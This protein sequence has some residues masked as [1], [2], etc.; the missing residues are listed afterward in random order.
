MTNGINVK[1]AREKVFKHI[2]LPYR[3]L[4]WYQ[5][6]GRLKVF[7][8]GDG[9]RI[10]DMEG[11]TYLDG[12]AGWQFGIV[13]HGRTEIGDAI[14]NQISELAV[15]APEFV[16]MSCLELAE[17]L[18]GIAPGDLTKVAFCN[19]GS[20]AVEAGMKM[21]KQYH[22]LNGEPTRHK[23]ISRRGSYHGVTW[24]CMSIMG[25]YRDMLSYF[26]PMVPMGIRVFHPYCYRCDF[27]LSY[28]SCDLQCAREIERVI[29]NEGPQN[30]SAVIGDTVS[31]SLG[32]VVPPPEYWPMV[33]SICDKYGILLISDEVVVGF[34]R[35]GKWFC[36]EHFDFLPDIICFAKGVTSGYIPCGGAITT[37]QIAAKIESGTNIGLVNFPTWGGNPVSTAGALA[38]LAIIERE[39]LVENSAN[40]GKYMLEGLK[41]R[42]SDHRIVGDIRGLGLLLGIEMVADKKMRAP[43]PAETDFVNRAIKK[44]EDEG[45]IARDFLSTIVLTPPLCLSKSDADEMI[46]IMERVVDGLAN[47][48]GY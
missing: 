1:E 41:D 40:I 29:V 13:G 5:E 8:K 28:P 20:E 15:I 22:V 21:A 31:H 23:V 14:R 3:S 37:P 6:P 34:G 36:C 26:D 7:V 46:D 45:M 44:M 33:R 43:F 17:K 9:V 16:N 11:N 39:S 18:A 4:S 24:G 27:G 2:F 47:D 12:A 10:T 30:V 48:L 38:N 32:V 42:L 25:V 19:S 35:T